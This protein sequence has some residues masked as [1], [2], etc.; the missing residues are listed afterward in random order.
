MLIDVN[1]FFLWLDWDD[2]RDSFGFIP[3]IGRVNDSQVCQFDPQRWSLFM[4]LVGIELIQN[5]DIFVPSLG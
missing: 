3:I 1:R 2:I 5:H 4:L